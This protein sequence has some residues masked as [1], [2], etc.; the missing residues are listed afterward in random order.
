MLHEISFGIHTGEV[1][2][3]IGK[4][5]MEQIK[6]FFNL[7]PSQHLLD[8]TYFYKQGVNELEIEES[9]RH[10]NGRQYQKYTLRLRLNFAR[11]LGISNYEVMPLTVR[12]VKK[13]MTL[14]NRIL[15]NTLRLDQQNN[16]LQEWAVIRLDTAFDIFVEYPELLMLLMNLSLGVPAKK[17]CNVSVPVDAEQF[18]KQLYES[19]RFGNDSYVYN[20]YVKWSE[21]LAKSKVATDAESQR[22]QYLVRL[23]RQNQESALKRLLSTKRRFGDLTGRSAIQRILRTMIND[24]E[25]F[26]GKGNFYSK[27]GV[28]GL[29]QKGNVDIGKYTDQLNLFLNGVLYRNQSVTK[30]FVNTMETLGIAP[31]ILTKALIERYGVSEIQGLY[32]MLITQYP[33]PKDK[34]GY[35]EFPIPHPKADGRYS[36][37]ITLHPVG[38][39]PSKVETAVGR[40]LE[41]YEADVFKRLKRTYVG[42]IRYLNS[43]DD[44]VRTAVEKSADDIFRFKN[45]ITSQEVEKAV[46]DFI[47]MTNLRPN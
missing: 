46:D 8:T 33:L 37:G 29:F 27:E 23:E 45:T 6:A 2:H 32:N 17:Q 13:V 1:E 22:L 28:K 35:H 18:R 25:A 12:N 44:K 15:R 30:D 34:R 11:V 4:Q 39:Y 47:K 10:Y 36:A 40:T 9:T 41:A 20:G 21:M 7:T 3:T 43:Q 38:T 14:I 16:D 42:N 5:E 24:V 31:A 26:W 19:I